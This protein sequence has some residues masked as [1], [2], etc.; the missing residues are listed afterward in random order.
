MIYMNES[1]KKGGNPAWVKGVSGNPRGKQVGTPNKINKEIKSKFLH[2]IQNNMDNMQEWLDIMSIQDPEKAA[3]F[4]VKLLPYFVP[5]LTEDVSENKGAPVFI[6][7]AG[8]DA[9]TINQAA[10]KLAEADDEDED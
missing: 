2:L 5:K 6:L 9:D 1:K 3:T 7:P 4:V 10:R 8:V